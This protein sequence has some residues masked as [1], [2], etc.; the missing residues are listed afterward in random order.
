MENFRK[1]LEEIKS[2]KDLLL[3]LDGF[4]SE[5][6]K[7]IVDLDTRIT[8][9]ENDKEVEDKDSDTFWKDV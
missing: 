4:I 9:L 1:K 8:Q 3:F 2:S 6:S 5:L 7:L